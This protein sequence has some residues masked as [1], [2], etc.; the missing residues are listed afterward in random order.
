VAAPPGAEA[1]G[2]AALAKVGVLPQYV[3]AF[4]RSHGIARLE[5]FGSILT[6]G[7]G[8]HSDVD[9]LVT[10]AAD[11]V[12]SLMGA[13][14]HETELAAMMRRRVDLVTRPSVE[15][16]ENRIRRESILGSA[17]TLYATG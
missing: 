6:D 8:P 2:L 4:A 15:K 13:A 5:V 1:A 9:V 10:Y 16:S 14:D 3:V 12:P 7:F 17:R 11:R